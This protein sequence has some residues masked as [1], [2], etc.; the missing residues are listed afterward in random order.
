LLVFVSAAALVH[1]GVTN[2]EGDV[3]GGWAFEPTQLYIGLTRLVFPFFG[4]LLLSRVA[5]LS[6]VNNAF[7]WSSILLMVVLAMPRIGGNENVWLNGLYDSLTIIFIFPIVVYLGASGDVNGKAAGRVCKFLGDI[8]YPIYITHYPIIYIYTGWVHNHK[9]KIEDTFVIAILSFVV[10]I[11]VAVL[12]LKF[13][14]VPLRKW[15][16]EKIFLS[17]ST[18][19]GN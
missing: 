9:A 5:K 1:L 16:A 17:R 4:G 10:S 19:Q 18:R 2:P 13:Y 15:L 6:F 14:D 7:L 8:S 12:L 3:I 11:V